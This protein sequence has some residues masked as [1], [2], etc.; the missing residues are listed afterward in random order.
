LDLFWKQVFS[1]ISVK[2]CGEAW[3]LKQTYLNY[4]M[5]NRSINTK[6]IESKF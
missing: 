5:M 3:T 6:N 2:A 4:W 1:Y